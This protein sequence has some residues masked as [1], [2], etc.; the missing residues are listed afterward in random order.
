MHICICICTNDCRYRY[1]TYEVI[2]I[3]TLQCFEDIIVD[4]LWDTHPAQTASAPPSESC[5]SSPV[6]MMGR[7]TTNAALACWMENRLHLPQIVWN[8][9]LVFCNS[10][11]VFCSITSNVFQAIHSCHHSYHSYPRCHWFETVQDD[12]TTN[13]RFS[14]CFFRL[15]M[16]INASFQ[17]CNTCRYAWGLR[18]YRSRMTPRRRAPRMFPSILPTRLHRPRSQG[19]HHTPV[20]FLKLLRRLVLGVI[21]YCS[22]ICYQMMV[23]QVQVWKWLVEYKPW[24]KDHITSQIT[25]TIRVLQDQPWVCHP[26]PHHCRFPTC[27]A[28]A[29]KPCIHGAGVTILTTTDGASVWGPQFG[30]RL[31]KHG[32]GHPVM[33]V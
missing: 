29:S 19:R 7:P 10:V 12:S 16:P 8:L 18:L 15:C 3:Y 22:N 23:Q 33:M 24:A 4:H 26:P 30:K 2:S 1:M 31:V 21:P 14:T 17:S 6:K 27:R 11:S 28:V 20:G 25:Q 9:G 5:W 13:D 32:R